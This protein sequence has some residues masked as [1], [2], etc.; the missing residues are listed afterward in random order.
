VLAEREP[1][2]ARMRAEW[3]VKQRQHAV[4]TDC[5]DPGVPI[6]KLARYRRT[7]LM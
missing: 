6:P 5:G 1:H 3:M 7:P 2:E 4:L